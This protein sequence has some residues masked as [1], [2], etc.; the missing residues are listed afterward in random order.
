[1]NSVDALIVVAAVGGATTVAL[2]GW[3]LADQRARRSQSPVWPS[4]TSRAAATAFVVLGGVI[5]AFVEPVIAVFWTLVALNFVLGQRENVPF[6]TYSMF[7]KPATSAWALRFEDPSGGLVPI[8]QMGISPHNQKKRFD[9]EVRAARAGGIADLDQAR[10]AAAAVLAIEI[11]EHRR[12]DGKW[13]GVPISIVLI[14]Y[15]IES[16][17][18]VTVHT[19]LVET[20]P[21]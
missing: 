2:F 13:A 15:D 17:S 21:E 18:L 6:S 20:R 9:T 1:M 12:P 5:A 19:S 8:R 14:E 16:G 11:E 3:L 4:K 10:R 7:S